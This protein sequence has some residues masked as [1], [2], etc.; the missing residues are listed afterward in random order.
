MRIGPHLRIGGEKVNKNTA[1]KKRGERKA[2][3]KNETPQDSQ[4]GRLAK[5]FGVPR[6]KSLPAQL[7]GGGRN[8]FEEKGPKEK[9]IVQHRVGCDS[10]IA[11]ARSLSIEEHEGE[12]KRRI[13]DKDIA[14][15]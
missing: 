14:I 8:T 15:D 10:Y 2:G 11:A 7:F 4:T 3:S 6:A 9:K 1:K 12:K 13:A 5:T